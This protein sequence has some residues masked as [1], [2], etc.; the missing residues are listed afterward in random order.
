M[1]PVNSLMAALQSAGM[2]KMTVTNETVYAMSNIS[3][4]TNDFS[5][6]LPGLAQVIP[7][8]PMNMSIEATSAPQ[9]HISSSIG[10]TAATN[11][12]FINQLT[13]KALFG[14][15]SSMNLG[16]KVQV[17]SNTM[18]LIDI[19]ELA[20]M[21]IKG[22]SNDQ[23]INADDVTAMGNDIGNMMS[24]AKNA[25]NLFVLSTPISIPENKIAT[26][27]GMDISMG[28]EQ[29]SLGCLLYTSPSPRD[30]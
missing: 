27:R 4:S 25:I 6:F 1:N 22:S 19:L 15:S 17:S 29:M 14:L 5:G 13:K 9:L 30:S 10:L 16:A 3:L 24:Y 8:A 2:L 21:G 7:S 20:L 11:I 26:I 23:K 18:I 12:E 28:S